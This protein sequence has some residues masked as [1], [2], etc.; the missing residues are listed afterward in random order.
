MNNKGTKERSEGLQFSEWQRVKISAVDAAFAVH[1][2]LGPGLLESAHESC[3]AYELE[4]RG[5]R[6]QRQ[7]P[8][9][10]HYKGRLIEL[11]FRAD[12]LF[13]QKLLVELKAVD[14]MLPVYEAQVI[15]YLKVLKLPLACSLTLT[16]SGSRTAS[17]ASST[18]REP[19]LPLSSFVPLL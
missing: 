12:V 8:V 4:L 6:C 7:L 1:V 18:F 2:E 11:G 10:L 19:R 9:P 16:P 13:E 3:F 17:I 14:V 5:I 15:T